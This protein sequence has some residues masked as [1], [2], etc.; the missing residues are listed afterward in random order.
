MQHSRRRRA[1]RRWQLVLLWTPQPP[2]LYLTRRVGIFYS[3]ELNRLTKNKLTFITPKLYPCKQRHLPTWVSSFI[4][5]LSKQAAEEASGPGWVLRPTAAKSRPDH[6]S[7]VLPGPAPRPPSQRPLPLQTD[8]GWFVP[9]MVPGRGVLLLGSSNSQFSFSPEYTSVPTKD[10]SIWCHMWSFFPCPDQA[11]ISPGKLL[12][13]GSS[14]LCKEVWNAERF[15][16]Y[17]ATDEK[18]YHKYKTI[19]PTQNKELNN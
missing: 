12:H 17:V 6:P 5:F 7:M 1:P 10:L 16:T 4:D 15:G 11:P 13:M 19:P 9:K 2:T 14:V 18:N 3:T 8:H